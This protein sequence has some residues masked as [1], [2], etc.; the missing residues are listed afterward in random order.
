MIRIG[1]DF[2][3]ENIKVSI[4]PNGKKIQ[5]FNL[6]SRQGV[7][8]ISRNVV[9][10]QMEDDG[11]IHSYFFGSREVEQNV[12][13]DDCIQHIK[14]ELSKEFY[15]RTICNGAK[16]LSA[17]D[18]TTDILSQVYKL[19][20]VNHAGEE[21]QA[22][23][24]VPVNFS[25]YQKKKLLQSAEKAGFHVVDVLTEPMASLFSPD[26]M[27]D[28]SKCGKGKN[29]V[30]FDFGGSTLDI[31]LATI[32]DCNGKTRIENIAS[33]GMQVGGVDIT[34]NI[35]EQIVK[36][37]FRE[38]LEQDTR[39]IGS[40]NA[41]FYGDVERV[42]REL[43]NPDAEEDDTTE[44]FFKGEELEFS[45][46][47]FNQF[48]KKNGIDRKIRQLFEQ[49]FDAIDDI[50]PDEV[51]EVFMIGGSSNITFF[52][53]LI[54]DI[55]D[56]EDIINTDIL[57]YEE[58]LYNSVANGA[59]NFMNCLEKFDVIRR[60]SMSIGID[61]GNGYEI[62]LNKNVT[63][64]E[65]GASKMISLE[66]LENHQWELRLYQSVSDAL[67]YGRQY[68]LDNPDICFA[69]VIGLNPALYQRDRDIYI[70]ISRTPESTIIDTF[71]LTDK[72][73]RKYIEQI[74][75]MRG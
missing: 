5:T 61:R 13:S 10:Y 46:D 3:M 33:T 11:E 67:V 24:T 72:K 28:N 31:C 43:Y 26:I 7:A 50:D 30:V 20:M 34:E 45:R 73:D 59:A 35:V 52:Q 48:L 36:P 15:E 56:N 21:A 18:I 1:I 44:L 23:M 40:V 65:K 64:A 49:L 74:D 62:F 69:G 12:L 42:K 53:D 32:S 29:V 4:C 19:V 41:G 25:E 68:P 6:D 54:R 17:E 2:G 16:T 38:E 63:Y 75:L 60:T 27:E 51:D 57:E 22:V 8:D 58:N 47:V 9:Y 71:Q 14:R 37:H 39:S 70:E 66:F 55:F